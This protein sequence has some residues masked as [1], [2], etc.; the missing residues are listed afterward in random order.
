MS[1]KKRV[2]NNYHWNIINKYLKK[3]FKYKEEQNK[4]QQV[5]HLLYK[6]TC[7]IVFSNA[8]EQFKFFV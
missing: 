2:E 3:K 8:N 1:L 5:E 4:I 7:I 6:H